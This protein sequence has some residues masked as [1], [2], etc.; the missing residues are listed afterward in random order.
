MTREKKKEGGGEGRD[1]RYTRGEGEERW[2]KVSNWM[3]RRRSHGQLKRSL[4]KVGGNNM[5]HYWSK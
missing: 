5:N 3:E 2:L 1:I 4:G